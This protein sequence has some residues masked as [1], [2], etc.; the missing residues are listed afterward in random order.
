MALLDGPYIINTSRRDLLICWTT[1]AAD[2]ASSEVKIGLTSNNLNQSY[3]STVSTPINTPLA[4]YL[5][6]VRVT[7]LLPLTKYFYT[8]G[9]IGNPPLTPA[10]NNLYFWTA[11]TIGD[12]S[13][14]RRFWVLADGGKSSNTQ[15]L[16][17]FYNFNTTYP[18]GNDRVDGFISIGDN[19]YSNGTVGSNGTAPFNSTVDEWGEYFFDNWFNVLKNSNLLI[20]QGNHDYAQGGCQSCGT[21]VIPAFQYFGYSRYTEAGGIAPFNP[22]FYSWD[23]GNIH[24]ISLDA[25]HSPSSDDPTDSTAV[26]SQQMRWLKNEI[27]FY[28]K[29]K[30]AGR[31]KWL[32]VIC[33]FPAFSDSGHRTFNDSSSYGTNFRN[34]IVPILN[35]GDVDLVLY[36]H[37]HNYYRTWFFH[38]YTGNSSTPFS[39]TTNV[40][41]P[42]VGS[43]GRG[44]NSAFPASVG[45]PY[46]KTNI[47]YGAIHIVQGNAN[48]GFY[49]TQGLYGGLIAASS[50]TISAGSYNTATTGSNG[51]TNLLNNC[52][53]NWLGS[54]VIDI[55]PGIG[56]G[57][58]DRLTYYHIFSVNNGLLP[59]GTIVD[60]FQIDK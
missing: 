36:G 42:Y 16:T 45:S 49:V 22:R 11:P 21:G 41:P 15:L 29:E 38:D 50:K 6:R 60:Y 40:W 58:R 26:N 57:G 5:H 39:N 4:S 54:G 30:L 19:A 27:E 25:Y 51:P 2:S 18:N 53:G 13:S 10:S 12:N 17:G 28:N 34:R 24:F 59:N 47:Y 8:V 14:K 56:T 1:D 3:R 55:E 31:K 7:G 20:T 35:Q 46:V 32:I 52:P 37:D 43:L 33:H 44:P 23:Y 9:R 48:T